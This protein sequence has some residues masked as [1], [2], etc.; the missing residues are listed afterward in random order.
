MTVTQSSEIVQQSNW[1]FIGKQGTFS[2]MLGGDKDYIMRV[3]ESGRPVV[4][5]SIRPRG[6]YKFNVAIDLMEGLN[7]YSHSYEFTEYG[8]QRLKEIITSKAHKKDTSLGNVYCFTYAGYTSLSDA[9][10]VANALAGLAEE[11]G[12]WTQNK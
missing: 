6:K 1:V 8:N 9:I 10:L 3:R 2:E 4:Y 5:I 7:F 11:K 12:I